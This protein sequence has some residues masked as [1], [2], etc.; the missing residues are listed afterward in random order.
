MAI[1][2]DK[3][4]KASDL[5][6]VV[7]VH[8]N[9]VRNWCKKGV[10]PGAIRIGKAYRI[11]KSEAD[12]WQKSPVLSADLKRRRESEPRDVPQVDPGQ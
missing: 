2:K 3:Y 11:P 7:G 6:R 4:I 12:A 9:T 10:F 8:E 5:A 1:V